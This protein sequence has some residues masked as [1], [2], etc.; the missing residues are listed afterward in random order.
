VH[1]W[2]C[3]TDGELGFDSAFSHSLTKL[4][5]LYLSGFY[6]DVKAL[7]LIFAWLIP[8]F[9]LACLLTAMSAAPFT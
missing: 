1:F 3:H 4:L 5:T 2:I 6:P 9:P 8:I 7:D